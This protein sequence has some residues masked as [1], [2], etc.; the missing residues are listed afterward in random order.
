MSFAFFT[1]PIANSNFPV[2]CANVSAAMADP[3]WRAWRDAEPHVQM[4][5]TV[6]A[7]RR[8]I[9]LGLQR[10]LEK[11]KREAR[12]IAKSGKIARQN[13]TLRKRRF[14]DQGTLR[15]GDALYS[16]AKMMR[17]K[18]EAL[19]MGRMGQVLLEATKLL[20][21]GQVALPGM[22]YTVSRG[23]LIQ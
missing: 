9:Q 12:N 13:L 14:S 23:W 5:F 10:A 6:R 2:S 4:P 11:R 7:V 1:L 3:D 22:A 19:R 17:P 8:A 18:R 21:A 20:M 15:S 16:Y